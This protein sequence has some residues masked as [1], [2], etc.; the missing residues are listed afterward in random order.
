MAW[1]KRDSNDGKNDFVLLCKKIETNQTSS[2][3]LTLL[4]SRYSSIWAIEGMVDTFCSSL[5]S[6]TSLVELHCLGFNFGVQGC[7]RLSQSLSRNNTLKRLTFGSN[8]TFDDDQ[9][10]AFLTS[11]P[12]GLEELD[13]ERKNLTPRAGSILAK[14]LS[15]VNNVRTLNLP[16]NSIGSEGL[17]ELCTLE[18]SKLAWLILPSNQISH[19]PPLLNSFTHLTRLNLSDNPIGPLGMI[20]LASLEC[21]ELV[22]NGCNGGDAGCIALALGKAR[23]KLSLSNNGLTA[24]GMYV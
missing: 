7:L 14:A 2:S 8:A 11:T 12:P 15:C 24:A 18:M 21:E 3:S 9:L 23:H 10:E 16:F 4:H 1:G 13:F 5:S 19:L 6:N 22:L 17:H 20:Q